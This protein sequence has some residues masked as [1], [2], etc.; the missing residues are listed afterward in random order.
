MGSIPT[1]TP[2]I[3]PVCKQAENSRFFMRKEG[4][5]LYRC[6]E[7]QHIF[8]WPMPTTESLKHIYSFAN[9]YQVQ[10]RLIY[11]ENTVVNKKLS[12]SFQ[13]I[14]RFS[15]R[16][17][18]LDI[19]CSSGKFL[20]LAKRNGWSVSGVEFNKDTAQIA[21]DNGL[22]VFVGELASA[23][24]PLAS[25]DAIHLGDVIEHV[26]DPADTLS[27]AS[28]LLKPNGVI[29]LITPNHD[30]VFPLL[31]LWLHRLFGLPWSHATPPYHLS[32][33][34]EKSLE[35]LLRQ[36]NLQAIEK[37]YSGC[38][39]H[40]EIGET[41]V[42]RSVRHALRERRRLVAAGRF[43]FAVLTVAAY[44]VVYVIDRCCVWKKR[45]F[46]MRFIIRKNQSA[47]QASTR[48]PAGFEAAS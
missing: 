23:G 44:G 18:L 19:G 3:C 46:Q 9:S 38:E 6:D 33:Y 7:C 47:E 17:R 45:D 29:V 39:L 4:C 14:E 42:F 31:T 27:R 12:E 21:S 1:S 25:F 11:D 30:A 10:N 2:A 34:S 37:Q 20:W 32:Q 35:K 24:Y 41:H 16:G 26:R 40:Y 13:Q 8:L 5:D 43:L 28:A 22:N 15:Q 36:L 48:T